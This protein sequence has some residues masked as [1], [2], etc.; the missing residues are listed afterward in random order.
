MGTSKN[1][2]NG[3]NPGGH[4]EQTFALLQNFML[5][6]GLINESMNEEEMQELLKASGEV[7]ASTDTNNN[8]LKKDKRKSKEIVNKKTT[9]EGK[10]EGKL[11]NM[12]KRDNV[13]EVTVYKRAVAQQQQEKGENVDQIER[14]IENIRQ[15]G[16]FSELNSRKI[17]SSSDELMDTSEENELNLENN[18]LSGDVHKLMQQK[19]V[20]HEDQAD[21]I[22]KDAECSKARMYDVKGKSPNNF[23]TRGLSNGLSTIQMD[24]DYQMLDT[25]VH[26]NTRKKI[27]EFE[28][29]EFSKLISKNRFMNEQDQHLELVNKNGRTFLTL[30]TDREM[31][32]ISSY[33]KWEQAFR[34]YSN[35]LTTCYPQK[36]TEVLQY[37]HTIQTASM[38]YVWENM[39]AYDWEFRRHIQRH[40]NRSWSV[41]LQQTW[42]MLLKDR[43]RNDY[44]QRNSFGNNGNNGNVSKGGNKR[45]P[46]RRFNKGQCTHG[47]S[48]KYDHRC[49]VK[50]CGKFGHGAHICRLR[51]MEQQGTPGTP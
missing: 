45:E 46:C 41:I 36:A 24:E 42:T 29:V 16:E 21:Q 31:V 51:N 40:P 25:H 20:T 6:K 37:G 11:L 23:D 15:E 26:E 35:I 47:L 3:H 28:Y 49:S 2:E 22:I 9:D 12:D 14:F 18:I 30:V 43:L 33:I 34:I 10:D 27:L 8:S 4:L 44:F 39:Y 32:Q 17:S 7:G 1:T 50:K 13:S 48:C 38:S 19:K 5:K